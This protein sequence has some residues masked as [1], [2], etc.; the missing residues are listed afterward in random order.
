MQTKAKLREIRKNRK[1]DGR[2]ATLA[3]VLN[4]VRKMCAQQERGHIYCLDEE[5]FEVFEEYVDDVFGGV[6]M[7]LEDVKR[8]L[9]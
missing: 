6:V 2:A 7:L 5:A 4:E 3:E 9:I 1:R 8:L